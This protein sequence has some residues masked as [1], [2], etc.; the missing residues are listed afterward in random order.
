MSWSWSCGLVFCLDAIC[1]LIVQRWAM[2]CWRCISDAMVTDCYTELV[3]NN[4]DELCYSWYITALICDSMMLTL[5]LWLRASV[6]VL[7]LLLRFAVLLTTLHVVSI[8][9]SHPDA[10]L[11]LLCLNFYPAYRLYSSLCQNIGYIFCS[12]RIVLAS[13]FRGRVPKFYFC[14]GRSP[15]AYLQHA[16]ELS[17][18]T[19]RPSPSSNG[20]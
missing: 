8:S 1:D 19:S 4:N 17:L 14:Y 9:V 18:F 11:T 16:P 5:R 12:Y 20:W 13:I 10:T 3:M 6:S 7:V 15:Q 2:T